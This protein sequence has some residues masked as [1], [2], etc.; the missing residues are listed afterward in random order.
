MHRLRA[1]AADTFK[2]K[3]LEVAPQVESDWNCVMCSQPLEAA[4]NRAKY[5][6]LWSLWVL[7][8]VCAVSL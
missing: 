4:P 1:E 3:T 7:C 6:G 2:E 8:Q 5:T